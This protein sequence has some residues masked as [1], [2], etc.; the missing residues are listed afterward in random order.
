MD[1]FDVAV[2]GV[3]V[4]SVASNVCSNYRPITST[5]VD[6]H[7]SHKCAQLVRQSLR[8]FMKLPEIINS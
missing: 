7:G 6:S 3:V 2:K 1:Y 8:P 5:G 4:Y